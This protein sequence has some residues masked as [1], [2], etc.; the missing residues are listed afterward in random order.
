MRRPKIVIEHTIL[1]LDCMLIHAM[2]Y[3]AYY[4]ILF[5]VIFSSAIDVTYVGWKWT[6]WLGRTWSKYVRVTLIQATD[7]PHEKGTV[8]LGQFIRE[9]QHSSNGSLGHWMPLAAQSTYCVAY[10]S[11][12]CSRSKLTGGQG[13]GRQFQFLAQF[14][15][16]INLPQS[17]INQSLNVIL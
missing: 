7:G 3:K 2:L 9:Q 17:F 5:C 1:R 6:K 13:W 12:V 16:K 15:P 4:V 14:G 8:L 10:A 11:W